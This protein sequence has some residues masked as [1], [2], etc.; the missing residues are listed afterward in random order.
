[1]S[2]ELITNAEAVKDKPIATV[3]VTV[4][5]HSVTFTE[6]KVAGL[7]IKKTAIAQ[8]V[9]IQLDFNLFRVEGSGHLKQ[10]G[11]HETVELHKGEQ[12]RAVTPDDN[13]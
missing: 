11:D 4:N 5:R 8:G 10:V 13:S 7:Q 1:M 9:P 12:F 2:T 3:M 6:R